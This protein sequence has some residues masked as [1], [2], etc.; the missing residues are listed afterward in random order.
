[1]AEKIQKT[2]NAAAVLK[3]FAVLESLADERR[4]SLADIAQRAVTSK[5]T[6]HRL[7]QTMVDLG[8]VEQEPETEKYGL[9]LKLFGLG[10]RSLRGQEDL[11]RICDREMGKLSRA[12][13]E[14]INL[15]V[16]DDF[17]QRVAYIHK[18]DSIYSLSM[19]STLGKRNP[20]HSTSLGKALL[21][22]RSDEEIRERLARMELRK[23]APRTITDPDALLENLMQTRAR[24]YAEEIEESEAG[25]RCLATPVLDH[26]GKSVAAISVA[27]PLIRFDETRK[28]EYVRLLTDAGRAASEALGYN[29]HQT[30]ADQT[31]A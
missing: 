29:R 3:V 6:A 4:A 10:A 12:T 1:M 27:F 13:G 7:L 30:R 15:G 17:D 8:Y 20:L 31:W 22:F 18:Y 23:L 11:L 21:A 14:S 26:V 16:L 19:Q 25:V 9:T 24:G 28:P 5:T 2:E